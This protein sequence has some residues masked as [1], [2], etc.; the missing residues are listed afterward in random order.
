MTTVLA[1][2]LRLPIAERAKDHDE[3]AEK[4]EHGCH[5]DQA[6]APADF[7]VVRDED[8]AQD[9]R[10]QSQDHRSPGSP[11]KARKEEI[12]AVEQPPDANDQQEDARQ[13][14]SSIVRLV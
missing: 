12:N 6:Q 7:V 8:H 13:C 3:S 11:P 14:D 9:Q 10:D 4:G 5:P 1:A 2:A